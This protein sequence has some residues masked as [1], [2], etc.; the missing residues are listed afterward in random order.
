MQRVNSAGG[1]CQGAV[2]W[3]EGRVLC[4]ALAKAVT[5]ITLTSA[6]LL[7]PLLLCAAPADGEMAVDGD[8]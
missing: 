8:A 3:E 1:E 6:C 5:Q 2:V 7:A 4:W